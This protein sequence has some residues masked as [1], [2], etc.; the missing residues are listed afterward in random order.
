MVKKVFWRTKDG[1]T[2]GMRERQGSKRVEATMMTVADVDACRYMSIHVDL[3]RM[4]RK[5][6]VGDF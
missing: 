6:P 5:T 2:M 3:R 1:H 4:L